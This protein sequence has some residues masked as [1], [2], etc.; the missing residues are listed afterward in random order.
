MS[1]SPLTDV[2][3]AVHS[4]ALTTGEVAQRTGLDAD[5]VSAAVEH[6]ARIGRIEVL[7]AGSPCG[8]AG[9]ACG[10]CALSGGGC[11]QSGS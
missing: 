6:L 10:G 3:L 1:T 2:L 5:V 4:G 11:A 9:D 8:G 7:G